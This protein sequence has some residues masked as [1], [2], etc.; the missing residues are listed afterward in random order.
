VIL[1]LQQLIN[2][3]S[4]GAIY[5]LIALGYTMVY[6]TLQLINFAHG[7]V[8]MMG[9]FAALYIARW[10]GVAANPTLPGVAV[11][12]VGASVERKVNGVKNAGYSC[13]LQRMA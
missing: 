2:G 8:Y 4:L 6:G 7:E 3:L 5:A 11:V 9:A 12:L 10:T 13:A 1:F